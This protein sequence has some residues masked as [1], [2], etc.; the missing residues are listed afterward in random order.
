[1]IAAGGARIF[2]S[3]VAPQVLRAEGT[4]S[5]AF[6]A[7]GPWRDPEPATLPL[8]RSA[9]IPLTT[10]LI[11]RPEEST[12]S[13]APQGTSTVDGTTGSG[14]SWILAPR[15][16]ATST[17]AAPITPATMSVAP[18]SLPSSSAGRRTDYVSQ[19]M[20]AGSGWLKARRTSDAA[21]AANR[22]GERGGFGQ[23]ACEPDRQSRQRAV[24]AEHRVRHRPRERGM[25]RPDEHPAGD[26]TR[27]QRGLE[28]STARSSRSSIR[29]RS[30]PA[31]GVSS[32]SAIPRLNSSSRR[33]L[34]RRTGLSGESARSPSFRREG[35]FCPRVRGGPA[36]TQSC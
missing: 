8:H 33:R 31:R 34:P 28:L 22:R 14:P 10:A 36:W 7:T 29:T 5:T 9:P 2:G 17:I 24:S 6:E 30:S 1:M 3:P 11:T 35:T 4:W 15:A 26:S 12:L 16:A 27:D 13:F 25:A 18:L 21:A 23:A 32:G 19:A 20:T